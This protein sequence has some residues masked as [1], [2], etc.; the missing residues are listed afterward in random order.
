MPLQPLRDQELSKPCILWSMLHRSPDAIYPKEGLQD[1]GSTGHI[2]HGHEGNN[3][4][5][6]LQSLS[7]DILDH[8][9]QVLLQQASNLTPGLMLPPK[10]TPLGPQL[11]HQ[12]LP[13]GGFLKHF[14][15][16]LLAAKKPH[17]KRP[18]TF[19]FV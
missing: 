11:H 10:K 14:D 4:N 3:L 12:G 18:T 19:L 7:L 9:P 2:Q 6:T 17:Q 16:R 8:D 15:Q 13:F 1:F 5:W